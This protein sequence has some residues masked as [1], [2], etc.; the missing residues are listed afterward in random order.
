[1]MIIIL[2]VTL[3]PQAT[4][5]RLVQRGKRAVK[6]LQEP[7]VKRALEDHLVLKA[8]REFQQVIIACFPKLR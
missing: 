8:K 3:E 5:D 2:Q 6:D 4:V 7:K 1:M